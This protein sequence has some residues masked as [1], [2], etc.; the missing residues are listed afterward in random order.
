MIADLN[1]F[2]KIH[3]KNVSAMRKRIKDRRLNVVEYRFD[4]PVSKVRKIS[5]PPGFDP[6][7]VQHVSSRYTDWATGPTLYKYEYNLKSEK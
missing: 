4:N 3:T 7:T 5:P 1:K 2:K 6:R